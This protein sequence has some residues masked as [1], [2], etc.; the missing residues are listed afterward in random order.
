M[1]NAPIQYEL[2]ILDV[3]PNGTVTDLTISEPCTRA[4]IF[5]SICLQFIHCGEDLITEIEQCEPLVGIIASWVRR[6]PLS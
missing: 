5:G 3:D 1:S 2:T 4:D 6:M